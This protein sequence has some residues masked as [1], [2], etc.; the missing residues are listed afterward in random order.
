[1][2]TLSYPVSTESIANPE[3]G[4]FYSVDITWQTNETPPLTPGLLDELRGQNI[5]LVRVYYS[6]YPFRQSAIPQEYLDRVQS[7]FDL[8]R[9]AGVK[10]IP[11]FVYVWNPTLQTGA[12]Q[13]AELSWVIRHIRQLTPVIQKNFDVI[14]HLQAGFVGYWGEMHSSTHS[15]INSDH[16]P[17]DSTRQIVEALLSMLPPQRMIALRYPN[18]IIGLYPQSLQVD[19]AFSGAAQARIGWHNDGLFWGPDD[20]GTY[21]HF[22]NEQAYLEQISQYVI[23]SGEPAI[24]DDYAMS[25]DPLDTFERLHWSELNTSWGD[26]L[27]LLERWKEVGA[28]AEIG[29][30]LGYRFRLTSATFPEKI[31][32]GAEFE[33]VLSVENEGFSSPHNPRPVKLVL[34]PQNEGSIY[35]LALADDPRRWSGGETT[36]LQV[37]AGLPPGMAKGVYDLFLWLPDPAFVLAARPEYAIRFANEEVWE[38]WSGYNL[39]GQVEVDFS[40]GGKEYSG[41]NQFS[42]TCSCDLPDGNRLP[43]GK[44]HAPGILKPSAVIPTLDIPLTGT[45]TFSEPPLPDSDMEPGDVKVNFDA[46]P[47]GN[48]GVPV[49]GLHFNSG[50]AVINFN[51]NL[52]LGMVSTAA[53]EELAVQIPAGKVLKSVTV[54]KLK[55]SSLDSISIESTASGNLP[56]QQNSLAPWWAAHLTG[57]KQASPSV[58]I[59]LNSG[60]PGGVSNILLDHF[61]YGDPPMPDLTLDFE[62]VPVE[63][64]NPVPFTGVYRG[65]DFGSSGWL[66]AT[67]GKSNYLYLAS[68]EKSASAAL[69]LPEDVIFRGVSIQAR[70]FHEGQG[71]SVDFSDEYEQSQRWTWFPVSEWQSGYETVWDHPHRKLVIRVEGDNPFG[72]SNLLIDFLRFSVP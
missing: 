36:R 71:I 42:P 37:L 65:V 27:N 60:A 19:A 34:R 62:D 48:L 50:W 9:Q 17:N 43:Q 41:E 63:V 3:R 35:T 68:S 30:R 11:R 45:I 5:T 67:D 57:W 14:D 40:A 4:W 54:R 32:P 59:A 16:S 61:V 58:T 70:E 21:N 69:S 18:T 72:A 49:E 6:L 53:E 52:A 51:G 66:L 28:Y 39:L 13:D 33:L 64:G 38:A 1:M 10:L 25:I 47:V 8:A 22:S 20:G 31:R 23:V 44:V 56:H 29:K 7:D 26:S 12:D 24:S 46:Q 2:Q 55:R 15:L